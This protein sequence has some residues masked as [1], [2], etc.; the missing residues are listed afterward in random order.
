MQLKSKFKCAL[1]TNLCKFVRFFHSGANA[2]IGGELFEF[3]NIEIL[4]LRRLKRAEISFNFRFTAKTTLS[5][6]FNYFYKFL[7]FYF[8]YWCTFSFVTFT[9]IK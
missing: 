1:Y 8:R 9:I 2:K 4:K 3:Y 6:H 5:S 7:S